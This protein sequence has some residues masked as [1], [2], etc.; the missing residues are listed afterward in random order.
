MSLDFTGPILMQ[1]HFLI[2]INYGVSDR[3]HTLTHHPFTTQPMETSLPYSSSRRSILTQTI[4]INLTLS[5]TNLLGIF[6]TLF[7]LTLRII[8]HL[9]L[10]ETLFFSVPVVLSWAHVSTMLTGNFTMCPKFLKHWFAHNRLNQYLMNWL[11]ILS[12]PGSIAY[13][14]IAS[15]SYLSTQSVFSFSF[16]RPN[17]QTPA[18]LLLLDSLNLYLNNNHVPWLRFLL[19]W[20]GKNPYNKQLREEWV[21]FAFTS[22]SYSGHDLEEGQEPGGGTWGRAMEGGLLIGC[23]LTASSVCF[24][25]TPSTITAHSELAPPTS[26]IYQE[27]A[28]Q[29]CP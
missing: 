24:L 13:L 22:K 11:C 9:S 12:F 21:Y 6:Q 16:E 8:D 17:N 26:T 20:G 5:P 15:L 2:F 25:I 28:P 10:L 7:I 1:H 3:T 18:S 4:V 27:N 23:L 19:L 29:P 14:Q